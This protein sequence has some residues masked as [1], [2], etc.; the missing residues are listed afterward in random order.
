[1]RDEE[2]NLEL[3]DVWCT[4]VERIKAR[5]YDV[6]A[7]TPPCSTWSRATFK[8]GGPSPVRDRDH[9][10][11]LPTL[12]PG[13]TAKAKCDSGSLLVQRSLQAC[14]LAH[15]VDAAYLLEHP[16]DL[17]MAPRGLPA[18]LWALPEAQQLAEDTD[19]TTVAVQQCNFGASSVRPTRFLTTLQ[20]VASLGWTGWPR[21][22]QKTFSYL[23]PLPL[24]CTCG[25]RRRPLV[26]KL[27]SG[28]FV[29]AAAAAYPPLLCRALA[30]RV[31]QTFLLAAPSDGQGQ[32]RG[33]LPNQPAGKVAGPESGEQQDF[34]EPPSE[35][36]NVRRQHASERLEAIATKLEETIRHHGVEAEDNGK[37]EELSEGSE[38]DAQ[39]VAIL[40]R[41]EGI[42]G[43]G[44][45]MRL[46]NTPYEDGC[47]VC[48]PGRWPPERRRLEPS[49]IAATL[50]L[51]LMLLLR[52]NLDIK[53]TLYKLCCGRFTENPFSEELLTAARQSLVES[54]RMRGATGAKA[55]K[56]TAASPIDLQVVHDYARLPEALPGS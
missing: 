37:D 56:T 32:D 41:G 5:A 17:G 4:V 10:W 46:R 2:Q 36:R 12:R 53:K 8:D 11:G 33:N 18:S 55:F 16:E 20:N 34:G 47:G 7:V 44:A 19:A 6:V 39:G 40:R 13:S 3:D 52:N 30:R 1:M 22:A 50:R 54:L 43:F 24:R 48:S 49:G 29:T 14:R 51:E 21:L 35:D 38:V 26:G 42:R 15:K 23:G 25:S 27:Q 31:W 9:P 45:Q 28:E